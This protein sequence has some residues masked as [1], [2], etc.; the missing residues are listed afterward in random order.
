MKR[1]ER[2]FIAL[3]YASWYK[4]FP[5]AFGREN[6]GRRAVWTI[7]IG[8]VVKQCADFMGFFTCFESGGRTDAV[9]QTASGKPWAKIEWE[10]Q[11]P[12]LPKV[13][14]L[15][16]LAEAASGDT[17]LLVYIGY[18]KDIDHA[19]N[20]KVIRK[21]WRSINKPLLALL[22]TYKW[23][24]PRR[25]FTSLQTHYLKAGRHKMIREQPALPWGMK[26]TVWHLL[27][28]KTTEE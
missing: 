2:D 11:Q 6:L 3:F 9:I 23:Q 10:W 7:H 14:E 13:N 20:I 12:H 17:E 28:D 18:S 25:R 1:Q 19:K 24:Y 16:K 21:A 5:V 26:N 27:A 4:D 15:K 22:V 8:S